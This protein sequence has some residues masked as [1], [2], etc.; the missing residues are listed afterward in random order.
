MLLIPIVNIDVPK[1]K[2]HAEVRRHSLS[3]D[4]RAQ[5]IRILR[6]FTIVLAVFYA[7]YVPATIY[8]TMH[9]TNNRS[10]VKDINIDVHLTSHTVKITFF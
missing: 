6:I 5:L 2:K 9:I 8:N 1:L 4:S 3:H 10:F 7:F